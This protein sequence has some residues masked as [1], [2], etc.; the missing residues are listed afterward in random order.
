MEFTLNGKTIGFDGDSQLSLLSFLREQQHL[1]S[2]KDGCS[3]QGACGACLVEMNGKAVLACRTLMETVAGASIVTIEGFP[4]RLRETLARAFVEKGAVQCG[5]CT[6]GFLSRTRILLQSN[7]DPTR[8]EIIKALAPHMCRCTGYV[9]IIDAILLAALALRENR[10]IEL[11]DTGPLGESLPKYDAYRKAIG[12]S[13]FVADIRRKDMVH[14]ALVFSAHARATV[15]RIDTAAAEALPGV[16]RV[17]TSRDIPGARITGHIKDDWPLMIEEGETT[18][19]IGD[20]LAGIV[21]ETEAI[22]RKAAEL[23]SID[24]EVLEPLTDMLVAENSPIRVHEQGNL[25]CKIHLQHG[26]AISTALAASAHVVTATYETQRVEHGF[27]ETEAAIAEPW[28]DDGIRI[29]VQ[30]QGIYE[31]CRCIASILN[32]PREKVD[33]TLIPCGGA[34]GGKEDLTVQGHAAL[35]AY[36]LKRPVLV[37]LDRGESLRMHPKRHP[38]IMRYQLGCDRNGRLTALKADITGDTGA[39]ASLGEAVLG[40]SASHAAGGYYVP[41]VD[42]VARAVYTNNVPCGAMRGFGVNQVTFAMECAVDE[43]CEMGGF[44]RWQFRYDN[45]LDNGLQT[46]TGQTL[47]SGVGLKETLLAV[48]E[49]F[50]QARYAGLAI[51]IKNIGFGNGLV[52]ESDVK[53]EIHSATRIVLHHGWT[54]MGQGIDTVA[55]QMFCEATGIETPG[56]IEI[57]R[58]TAAG[59]VGGTT[60][61][62]RGTFLLGNAIIDAARQIKKDLQQSTLADLAG[63]TYWGRWRCDWTNEPGSSKT[64]ITHV[65]YGY[66]SQVVILADD[67]SVQ[68]VVAAH[69]VGKAINPRLL[70]GQIEGGVVMGLG[71]AF[72]EELPM[73]N[74]Q[75]KTT[76]FGK[77]GIPRIKQVPE[78][79]VKLIEVPDPYGPFGAKGVG[80][81]GLVPTAAAAANARFQFDGKRV[82]RLPIKPG[83]A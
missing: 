54:E 81:I 19:T 59:I 49:D 55:I 15:R 28:E 3:G 5:F 69:D 20:V 42:I 52:D 26:E 23:V 70:E 2:V 61:A 4:P 40:R 78:I 60:T 22:A 74:G 24:Y 47:I 80:E 56:I 35:F 76:R 82:Y 72:S 1:T 79:V 62:S 21:A 51:G 44:D 7:P 10:E 66:A 18:R 68:K 67:G 33:V 58:S 41:T 13:D 34:F 17:F 27:L 6:P 73:E 9:K 12:Q 29:F 45:A 39:Y 48:K 25:L 77:L 46:T 38:M 43:L 64:S 8:Q 14:G 63:K 71:Y 30:S 83:T 75:L 16:L 31:D 37:R 32:L 50:Q 57:A 65:A 36:H 53:I 11:P